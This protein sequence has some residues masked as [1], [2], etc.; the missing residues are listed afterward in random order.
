MELELEQ[1]TFILKNY[2]EGT[3]DENMLRLQMDPE[4]NRIWGDLVSISTLFKV[5]KVAN[6]RW[7][8]ISDK[9]YLHVHENP[10]LLTPIWILSN[11]SF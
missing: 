2:K 11:W 8:V 6:A 4:M 7:S 9:V 5:W 10:Q 3:Y 1:W